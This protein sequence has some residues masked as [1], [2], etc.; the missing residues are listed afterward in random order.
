MVFFPSGPYSTVTP[1]ARA[2]RGS[3]ALCPALLDAKKGFENFV[4]TALVRPSLVNQL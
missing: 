1:P 2:Y 3:A 4:L